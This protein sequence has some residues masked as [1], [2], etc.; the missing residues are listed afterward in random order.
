MLGQV[1][2]KI[3]NIPLSDQ[4][5]FGND[6]GF[7]Y[8]IRKADRSCE[9]DF[10]VFDRHI[11]I[12]KRHLGVPDFVALQ[13][14]HSGGRSFLALLANVYR[15]GARHPRTNGT[16]VPRPGDV[17]LRGHRQEQKRRHPEGCRQLP[18]P[19]PTLG[20]WGSR[21]RC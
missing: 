18:H 1:D 10:S 12:V 4:T 20:M 9:H 5:Q 6:E 2:N 11:K 14:W 15:A 21:P 13:V 8:W 3:V 7:V 17:S 16:T 19:P